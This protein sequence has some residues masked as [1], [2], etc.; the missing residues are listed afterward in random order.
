M[1]T[2]W[3]YSVWSL[4]VSYGTPIKLKNIVTTYTFYLRIAADFQHLLH[5]YSI[6]T[7]VKLCLTYVKY[8]N[9]YIMTTLLLISISKAS[10][11]SAKQLQ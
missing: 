9:V 2:S 11:C 10:Q 6:K 1:K 8:V 7:V 4:F 5:S 3:L